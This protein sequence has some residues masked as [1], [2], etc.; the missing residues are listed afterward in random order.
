MTIINIEELEHLSNENSLVEETTLKARD[1]LK[2]SPYSDGTID[3]LARLVELRSRIKDRGTICRAD[4][5]DLA[6]LSSENSVLSNHL[7]RYPVSFYS[8][9]LSTIL[10]DETMVSIENSVVKS[11]SDTLSTI[12]RFIGNHGGSAIDYIKEVFD[13]DARTNASIAKVNILVEYITKTRAILESSG[14]ARKISSDLK[15][16][17][18]SLYDEYT[19]KWNGLKSAMSSSD[20]EMNWLSESIA[21]PVIDAYPKTMAAATELIEGLSKT[22][23]SADVDKL[24]KNYSKPNINITRL[25]KWVSK[26]IQL[27]KVVRTEGVMSEFQ[28][29]A[30]TVRS[31]IKS[32]QNNRTDKPPFKFKDTLATMSGMEWVTTKVVSED[33]LKR[34]E[35]VSKSQSD[36]SNKMDRLTKDLVLDESLGHAALP[37]VLELLSIVRGFGALVDSIGIITLVK[38]ELVNE[39]LKSLTKAVGSIHQIVRDRRQDL[40][41]GEISNLNKLTKELK[42]AL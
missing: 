23:T 22:K 26:H 35:E 38:R 6:E 29:L 7:R 41:V 36:I 13:E 5:N 21:L 11:M 16:V 25:K 10:Y 1:S 27:N 14:I 3:T 42:E 17:D 39:Q 24:I 40:T 15:Y 30:M 9:S 31:H 19:S 4:V 12:T 37:I 8:E 32:L 18:E 2:N 33:I 34:A 28:S 20:K